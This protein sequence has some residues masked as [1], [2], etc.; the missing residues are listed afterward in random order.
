MKAL[1]LV[2][3]AIVALALLALPHFLKNYGIYLLSYWLIYII[4]TIRMLNGIHASGVNSLHCQLARYK[5]IVMAFPGV[6]K[7]SPIVKYP[8]TYSPSGKSS[9]ASAARIGAEVEGRELM[10]F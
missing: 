6:A 9:K 2:L 3:A 5:R 4:A 8:P 10:V 7:P 1:H